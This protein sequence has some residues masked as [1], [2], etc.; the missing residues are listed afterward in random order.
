MANEERSLDDAAARREERDANA[1]HGGRSARDD[2][3]DEGDDPSGTGTL[4][5][6]GLVELGERRTG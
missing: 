3:D 6:A 5:C 4:A 1:R 2:A